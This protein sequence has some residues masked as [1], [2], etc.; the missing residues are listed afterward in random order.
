MGTSRTPNRRPRG[1]RAAI[2][3]AAVAALGASLLAGC[4]SDSDDTGNSGNGGSGSSGGK[5]KTTITVGTFGVF[6]YKQAGLYAEYEKLHPDITIKENVITDS[7][8]YYS[9]LLTHLQAG[10]GL[11]DVQAIEVGNINEVVT[12]QAAKFEDLSKAPGVEKSNWLDWKWAQGTTADGRTVG[13]GTDIGPMAICYQPALFKAAGLP[14]DR[15]AVGK[16]WAGDWQKYVDAGKQYTKKAPAG[17]AFMDSAAGL[18]NAVV[19]S[20][21]EAYY[22]KSGKVVYKTSTS[23]KTAWNLAMEAA[24]GKMTTKLKQFDPSWNQAMANGKFASIAC[25]AWM[26]GYI[27]Q[28]AGDKGSGKW[29]VAAAPKSSNWGGSFVGV[30]TGGKH[31]K[32]AEALAV[33]L[34]APEQQ[35]KVF[36]AQASFPSAPAAYDLPDVKDATNSYLS[37]APTGQIFSAAAKEIPTQVIGPKDGKIKTAITDIGILQVEQQ[38]KTPAQGWAAAEK[39]IDD[40]LDQ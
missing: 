40:L 11:D 4:A 14:S 17:T 19:S 27:K 2:A 12:T 34:T 31:T 5:G 24:T 21:P 8:T 13:L 23:V 32:E 1:R 26:G 7:N 18:Y 9:T 36:K 37:N 38:G 30:P 39:T 20:Y 29:D 6:G 25:P 16:L 28:Q 22:D 10:S 35:A 15:E 3:L 33:W